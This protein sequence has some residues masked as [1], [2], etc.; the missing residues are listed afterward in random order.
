MLSEKEVAKKIKDGGVLARVSF[1]II[2][3]PREHVEQSLKLY[4]DN[5]KK[6][7]QIHF[8][9]EDIG[10]PEEVSE[11]VFS[12]FAD[13]EVVVESL[14]KLNW[15]C[16]NFMP[17]NIEIIEPVEPKFSDKDLTN[18]FNDLL[19]KLHEVST[20]YRQLATKEKAFV[21]NMNAMIHNAI[22]LAAEH[23]HTLKE[24]S[25]KTGIE[26]KELEKFLESNVKSGHIEE[27]DG[28]FYRKH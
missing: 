24:I 5:L 26:E 12:T 4:L 15:L 17:A 16:V 3:S 2:G 25:A 11:G 23:Y 21:T 9:H 27:K 20:N 8:M 19:S 6:D 28:K 13:T 18:W 10:E 22:L 1:E 14:D 7:H